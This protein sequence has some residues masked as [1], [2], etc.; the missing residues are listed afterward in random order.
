[1]TIFRTNKTPDEIKCQNPEGINTRLY[2]MDELSTDYLKHL[3]E[4]ELETDEIKKKEL[5]EN[6]PEIVIKIK[7]PNFHPELR[8]IDSPGLTN[9]TMIERLFKLLNE[10]F[11]MSIFVYLRSFIQEKV[12]NNGMIYKFFNKIKENYN[13]SIFCVCL[14]KYD[15]FLKKF[16][17]GSDYYMPDSNKKIN[18]NKDAKKFIEKFQDF[19]IN[20]LKDLSSYVLISKIFINDNKHSLDNLSNLN[21][22]SR[23]QIKNFIDYLNSINSQTAE[24]IRINFFIRS[25]ITRLHNINQKYSLN[26]FL[27]E[28]ETNSVRNLFD[29][30]DVKFTDEIKKWKNNFS[31][32][33][34]NFKKS[35]EEKLNKLKDIFDFHDRTILKDKKYAIKKTY[36]KEQKE[37]LSDDMTK[38]IEEDLKIIMDDCYVSMMNELPDSLKQK[39]NNWMYE[40]TKYDL[41][42]G[43][44]IWKEAFGLF[45]SAGIGVIT[46]AAT[47][48]IAGEF[49]GA[50]TIAALSGPPGWIIGSIVGA[51]FLAFSLSDYIG[52]WT[53]N[54]SFDDVIK[55]FY[56]SI[57]A[58]IDEIIKISTDKYKIF[59][60]NLKD[61][62]VQ[63]KET[64]S[65]ITFLHQILSTNETKNIDHIKEIPE[66][67]FKKALQDFEEKDEIKDIFA[68]VIFYEKNIK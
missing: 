12:T 37:L 47:V 51:G 32:T 28:K 31:S 61:Y 38:L 39:F 3:E 34:E 68:K 19:K 54:N 46:R 29:K 53:R 62:L 27:N 60:S 8:L 52:C 4:W 35:K 15:Q 21:E 24:S 40:N 22:K 56:E 26:M 1:M 66:E 59:I 41:K 58:N 64:S 45:F 11:I 48:S 20:D 55:L 50:S 44:N 65:K 49:A 16:L 5:E 33:Y 63:L 57:A 14:T 42:Q 36:V 13:N 23:K 30:S 2:D 25:M 67:L 17:K 43:I 10:K 18:K 9:K 6:I 7:I